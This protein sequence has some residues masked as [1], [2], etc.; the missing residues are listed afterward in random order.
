M[1]QILIIQTAFIGDAILAT[2]LVE[3]IHD[4]LP[5][6]KIDFVLRKGNERLLLGNPAISSVFVWTKK[7]GKYKSLLKT[8]REIR[9][10]K[11]DLVINLQ[12]FW[13]SGFLSLR[14]KATMKIGFK[15]NPLSVF[16]SKAIVHDVNSGKHEVQRNLELAQLALPALKMA[17]PKLYFSAEDQRAV[18]EVSG[19]VGPYVVMAPS[20][21]WFTKQLPEQKWVDLIKKIGTD[22]TVFLVGGPEDS[23]LL[24]RIADASGKFNS[25]NLAGKL[26]L[27]A[28]ALLMK[29]AV[30]NYV[31]D[32][33]PLH[34]ASAVNAPVTAFFCSTIPEFGFGPLSDQSKVV[35]VSEKL[36]CRPCG[37]HGH[38]SCPQ[39]HFN[40]GNQIAIIP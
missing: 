12:R 21:V 20:S 36:S 8:A 9:Q 34:L 19:T 3:S 37:I 7:E 17:R 25:V 38:K 35:E 2:A 31:N 14:A 23:P 13:S 5:E 18:S 22:Q 27:T 10:Q 26:S 24:Q 28:S 4:L 39:G 11:Y 33:A 30:M 29:N 6:A 32:S 16:Y 40:C 15:N 1:K